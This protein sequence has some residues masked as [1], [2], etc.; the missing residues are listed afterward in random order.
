MSETAAAVSEIVETLEDVSVE[1]EVVLGETFMPVHQLLRMGRGAVIELNTT[2]ADD[3]IILA[4]D[5]PVAQAGIIVNE[6]R[7]G[8]SI[9][10]LFRRPLSAGGNL[11][12]EDAVEAA[13]KARDEV[14]IPLKEGELA[15]T[16][17]ETPEKPAE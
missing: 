9:T 13:A 7:I 3:V 4:N 10:K 12:L 11:R 16:A 15:G 5:V 8:I 14:K 1:I 17:E 2:E 6:G